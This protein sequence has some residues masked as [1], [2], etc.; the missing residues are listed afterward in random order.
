MRTT[1]VRVF[2]LFFIFSRVNFLKIKQTSD[3]TFKDTSLC[4]SA[5]Q[6]LSKI[7]PTAT[8]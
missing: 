5:A 8:L 2:V 7:H 6:I 3:E 4:A 1:N